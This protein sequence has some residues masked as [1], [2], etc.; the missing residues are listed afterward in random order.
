MI[1]KDSK[2][3]FM[4]VEANSVYDDTKTT[5]KYVKLMLH[6]ILYNIML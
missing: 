2:I 6:V 5:Q 1:H 3:V 4:D